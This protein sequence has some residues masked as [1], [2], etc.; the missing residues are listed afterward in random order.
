MNS[1]QENYEKYESFE[2]LFNPLLVDR[3]ARRKRR[4]KPGY[5]VKRTEDEV[6]ANAADPV[7]LEA[8]LNITYKPSRHEADWLFFSLRPFYD[9]ELISDIEALVKGGKEANVYRCKAHPATGEKWLAAK[10]YR[11]RFFRNLR[12]DHA[13]RRGRMTLDTNGRPLKANDKRLTKALN[14]K[15]NLGQQMMHTSWL[16][17]E[18]TTLEMLYDAGAAVPKPFAAGDNAILMSY[19]GDEYGAAQALNE[20]NLDPDEGWALFREVLENIRLMLSYGR[21]HADL[22]AY[23]ILYWQGEV[24]LIDFPQVINSY[25]G[26]ETHIVGSQVNPDAAAILERDIT[27]VC[28]YF[29]GQGL[30]CDAGT[31]FEEM[32]GRYVTEDPELQ[33]ADAS[34]WEELGDTAE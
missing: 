29:T 9:Q 25:V 16:M 10:V 12:N 11:P 4:S 21:V 27:R 34:A 18:Y 3:Q 23:N 13:Y 33:L 7:G 28:D 6:I 30:R 5:K 19:I 32:W 24:T 17:H 2:E 20:I 14:K 8:G 1:N 31:I 15:S 22:S 26:K